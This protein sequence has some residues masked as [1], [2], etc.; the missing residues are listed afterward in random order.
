MRAS[1]H[2]AMHASDPRASEKGRS[3]QTYR[4]G[5]PRPARKRRR[6]FLRPLSGWFR[7]LERKG[8]LWLARHFYPHLPRAHLPYEWQLRPG[9][10]RRGLI[11]AEGDVELAGLPPALDGLRIL[12]ITDLHLGPFL[13]SSGLA[14]VLD[15]L[16]TLDFDLLLYGGDF[17]TSRVEDVTPSLDALRGLRAPL[18]AFG[19]LG[20][21]DHYTGEPER[22]GREIET[23]GIRLL[24]NRSEVVERNGGALA[25]AGIDDLLMGA[26]DL[27]RALRDVPA[28]L[29]TILLS[30]HPDIL[31]DAA[32]RGIPLVLSGHTHGGQIR[33]PGLPVIVRMS[34]YRLDEGRYRVARGRESDPEG[35]PKGKPEGDPEG[36]GT[37]VTEIVVSRGLGA[38]GVPLRVACPPEVVLLRLRATIENEKGRT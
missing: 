5:D 37:G 26:P 23:A 11:I 6:R 13:S 33:V 21:H 15:R 12:L 36:R 25:L 38:V 2:E 34:R 32:E 28:G 35:D 30:H 3:I 1:I 16:S 9:L 20:N 8:S 19:V 29:P 18:G 4:L 10:L 24:E 31:F 14:A 7:R 17:A 22:L 27:E